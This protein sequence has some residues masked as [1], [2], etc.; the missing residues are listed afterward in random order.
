[1]N[2]YCQ[3]HFHNFSDTAWNDWNPS[4]DV[5]RAI[6]L[7]SYQANLAAFPGGLPQDD[8]LRL[9]RSALT[10]PAVLAFPD[11]PSLLIKAENEDRDQAILVL[12]QAMLRMLTALPAG[13]V[14]FT[15]IDP[16]G[17]GQNF[18]AFMHLA[19]FDERLVA[20]RIW[21]ETSH[22]GKRLADLTEHMEN[23]IQKY[24]RN[25]FASIQAYN[26]AAGEVAEPFQVL[27]IANFPANFSEEAARRLVS[28]ASSGARCGVFT[29]ISTDT[30]MKL[31]RNFDLRDLEA[32]ANT[33]RV[34]DGTFRWQAEALADFPLSYHLPPSEETVTE[35]IRAAGQHA[36]EANK[37]E[38]PFDAVVPPVGEWWTHDSRRGIE[39]PLGRAGATKLQYL[40]L[41]KGTSQHVLVAGKTGSGKSTL[42]HALV[43][44]LALHYS[45]DELQFYLMDF[46]KGVEFKTYAA[47]Q[48]PH[49]RVVAIESEREFGLSVLQNVWTKSCSGAATC[50]A[51]PACNRWPDFATHVPTSRCRDCCCWLTSFRSSLS[52]TTRSPAR[53]RCCST[54]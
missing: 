40:R 26:D 42:L 13:K 1:M 5:P 33:L 28:I 6:P 22:I 38:V 21:T 19:D 10:W 50:F 37:V 30:K 43:T 2:E 12:Q 34:Q 11:S 4:A 45:P 49:A 53:P 54:D 15:I 29:L 9:D 3:L 16:T 52:T 24:L 27:V 20:S 25:E 32:Q 18:S 47:Y 48:L 31:P 51:A 8:Q 23:V 17:L 35:I 44:N 14:R 39:V 7:G 41:G 46:K 36:T